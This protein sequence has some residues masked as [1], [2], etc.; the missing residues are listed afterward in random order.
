MLYVDVCDEA[1]PVIK[2]NSV[3]RRGAAKH[4]GFKAHLRP[5]SVKVGCR[6]S[7]RD[8]VS[9]PSLQ[10]LT[11]TCKDSRLAHSS[12]RGARGSSLTGEGVPSH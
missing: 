1:T 5:A 7:T 8:V 9:C 3:N 2:K 6:E 11:D 12:S 10:N 4:P